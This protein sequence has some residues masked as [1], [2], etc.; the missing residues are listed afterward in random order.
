[1][2]LMVLGSSTVLAAEGTE[3]RKGSET[4]MNYAY[5]GCR[6]TAKRYAHGKGISV[7][8]IDAK[9]EWKLQSITPTLDN[10]AFL[11]LDRD[12]KALYTV[13][14]DGHQVSAFKIQPDGDLEFLNTVEAQGKNPVYA[15]P[16]FNNRFLFVATLQGG[17]VASLPI[18]E[19]GSLGEAVSTAHLEGKPGKGV[20]HA[21][22]CVLDRTGKFLL[23][24]TQARGVGYERVWVFQVDQE[25]GKLDLVSS[26]DSRTYDE[27][28][29]LVFSPDNRRVYLVNEKGSTL[30]MLAFDADK[31]IL[32]PE[33]VVP[34]LPE[35]YV[36]PNMA[37]AIVMSQDGRFV[38]ATNRIHEGIPPEGED[39][40]YGAFR[41]QETL[42]SYEVDKKTGMLKK[43]QWVSCEGYTPR[44]MTLTPDG[45]ELVV[46]NMDSDTLQF[47]S[48]EK[49]GQ[50]RF[51]GKT[52]KTESPCAL[53]FR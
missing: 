13:H 26:A 19:D 49:N 22:A 33:Q 29:H 10:P 1:M 32:T 3:K 44:F 6:T 53:V 5:V 50:P 51:T 45:K 48:L 46:A 27:P 30:R 47:F 23:V 4:K 28:R 37:S 39:P 15:V 11:T 36:G 40:A 9:R 21:H 31:G 17:A 34:T 38:Y 14:G 8:A 18:R 25:T 7:Y 35:T 20:S 43:P 42:V 2:V 52:V 41:G 12:R 16:S 24:P